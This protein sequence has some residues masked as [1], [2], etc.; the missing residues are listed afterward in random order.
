MCLP[1]AA[2]DLEADFYLSLELLRST[3]DHFEFCVVRDWIK[4][5]LGPLCEGGVAQVEV[6]KSVLKQVCGSRDRCQGA[7]SATSGEHAAVSAAGDWGR[8]ASWV[9]V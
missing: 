5:A 4:D 3:K 9:C 8:V 1:S 6:P 2:G 7:V